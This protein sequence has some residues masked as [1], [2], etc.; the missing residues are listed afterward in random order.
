[1]SWKL[2]PCE[3]D[4]ERHT[5]ETETCPDCGGDGELFGSWDACPTCDGT[6]RVPLDPED[7]AERIAE[8]QMDQGFEE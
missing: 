7:M 2:L 8:W 5:A 3:R 4:A 6:G 1:M